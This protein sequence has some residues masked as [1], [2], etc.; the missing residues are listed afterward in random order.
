MQDVGETERE[1]ECVCLQVHL[2]EDECVGV[3]FEIQS[4][5]YE[6]WVMESV[7]DAK[8]FEERNRV[9]YI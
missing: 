9:G 5:R 6:V 2:W 8:I 3:W 7:I 4:V 1:G